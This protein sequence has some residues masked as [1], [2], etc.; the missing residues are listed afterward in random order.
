[1]PFKRVWDDS[2]PK[3]YEQWEKNG[4]KYTVQDLRPEDDDIATEMFLEH[5]LPDEVMC[6]TNGKRFISMSTI[7]VKARLC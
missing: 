1:M 5:F 4:A 3:I 7:D 6:N 2:C